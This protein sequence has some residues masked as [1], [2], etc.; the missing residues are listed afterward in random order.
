M[1]HLRIRELV[2]KD[3]IV[4]CI[5]AHLRYEGVSRR[6]LE[7]IGLFIF[8]VQCWNQPVFLNNG[9]RREEVQ[10]ADSLTMN[11][12][13]NERVGKFPSGSMTSILIRTRSTSYIVVK[14]VNTESKKLKNLE[15]SAALLYLKVE[16]TSCPHVWVWESLCTCVSYMIVLQN[17]RWTNSLTVISPLN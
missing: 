1:W 15:E 6:V 3:F 5:L 14:E 8:V 11:E 13:M 9:W 4:K 12:W 2:D 7:S 17:N 16:S 10:W